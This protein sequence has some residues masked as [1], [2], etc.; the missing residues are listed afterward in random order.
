MSRPKHFWFES[1]CVLVPSTL[2]DACGVAHE[3]QSLSDVRGTD[4]RS[5]H[6]DRPAGVVFTFQV[7]LNKVEPAVVNCCFNLLSKDD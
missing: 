4:A 1:I 3:P 2:S 5:R 7:S 6:T